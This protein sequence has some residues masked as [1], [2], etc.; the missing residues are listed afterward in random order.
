MVV[1]KKKVTKKAASKKVK[2]TSSQVK[3]DLSKPIQWAKNMSVEEKNIDSQHQNLVKNVNLLL[4]VS[5]EGEDLNKIR[6]VLHFLESYVTEHFGYEEAYMRKIKYPGFKKHQKVHQSLVVYFIDFKNRLVKKVYGEKNQVTLT[7]DVSGMLT[8]LRNY[9]ADWLIKH[10]LGEDQGFHQYAQSKKLIGKD[11]S[12]EIWAE[13]KLSKKKISVSDD[14][15]LVSL[16]KK[17]N[18]KESA[19]SNIADKVREKLIGEQRSPLTK[20]PYLD[21]KKNPTKYTFTG[22]EGF[23]ELLL[24]GLPVGNSVIVA[25][26]AGSGKTIFC[27]QT[28]VN[29]ANEGNRCLYMTLEENE[30]KLVQHMEG[31]GWNPRELIKKGKLK[32]MRMNPFDITRNVDALLAKQKG[33]LLIDVDPVL[34]PKDYA[35]PDFLVIDSLT[36]IA[37]AFTGKDDSYRIYIEQLFRFLEKTGATSFLITETEQVPTIFSQT[38]VEEFLADGVVVLYSL[39]HGNIRENAIEILKLRGAAHQ[40]KIV[41]MQITSKGVIV[42]PEQEVF[43]EV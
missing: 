11:Y 8:E 12:K 38:G 6:E 4:S 25:G 43:S 16:P 19:I 27:L 28:L 41:A 1:K 37:S 32:I 5:H 30:E 15:P 14:L 33:E 17:E 35:K 39:K 18:K 3:M 9:L 23:D 31:F 36:A 42:Y 21:I 40:K 2:L 34:L 13:L 7:G 10:M 29:K 26:G 22:V 20:V 24:Q